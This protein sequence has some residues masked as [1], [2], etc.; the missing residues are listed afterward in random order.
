MGQGVNK[1]VVSET[2]RT[3]PPMRS[4]SRFWN[5]V[6]IEGVDRC[7]SGGVAVKVARTNWCQPFRRHVDD[8]FG[9][10]PV[11]VVLELYE[12]CHA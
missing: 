2:K 11:V 9:V 5:R 4:S 7:E 1:M 6:S 8:V 3:R 12:H 10:C